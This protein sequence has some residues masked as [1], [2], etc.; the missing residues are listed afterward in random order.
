[1]VK[2]G[3][4]TLTLSGNNSG[5]TGSLVV[6]AGTLEATDAAA[7]PGFG[8]G[9]VSVAVGATLQADLA[10][11]GGDG[12]TSTN[13]ASLLADTSFNIDS[14][15]DPPSLSFL[16]FNFPSGTFTWGSISAAFGLVV[17]G[18]GT[19]VLDGGNSF[20]STDVASGTLDVEGSITGP[21]AAN[22]G[23][24]IG[25]GAPAIPTLSVN[26]S[27]VTAVIGQAALAS[28]QWSDSTT[29]PVTVT[30]P[31]GLLTPNPDG[32]WNWTFTPATPLP[33]PQ[34]ETITA[35]D[36]STNA[37]ATQT[38]TVDWLAP[39]ST[40]VS[41]L[42]GTA[43]TA[44]APVTIQASVS[45]DSGTPA[46][47][48]AFYDGTA[49]LG[50]VPL[51]AAGE[52]NLGGSALAMLKLPTLGP[53]D[54][55]ITAVYE[56]AG[57][58]AASSCEPL[59]VT[60]APAAIAPVFACT[61]SPAPTEGAPCQLDASE[62]GDSNAISSWTVN[63]GDGTSPQVIFTSYDFISVTHAYQSGGV[64]CL[65]HVS[66]TDNQGNTYGAFYQANLSGGLDPQFGV[67]GVVI[68]PLPPGEGQGEGISN[69]AV[70]PDGS[71]LAVQCSTGSPPASSLVRFDASGDPDGTTFDDV[72]S[73]ILAIAAIA[74]QPTVLSAARDADGAILRCV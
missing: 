36:T 47:D 51:D 24:V 74:I 70:Q 33:G 5:F 42:P 56:G 60:V 63:W 58:F 30:A 65:V 9:G 69:L 4:G 35:L 44:A 67:G 38:V 34:T 14:S 53:G 50:T 28:G 8:R 49:L 55:G 40:S 45:A 73:Q 64:T 54:H 20:A 23:Q 41:I 17:Q 3:N 18:D 31:D 52:I 1:M 61:W 37:A 11:D 22:G 25:G 19:L 62:T 6:Q 10:V 71:I 66:E 48:V 16:A 72:S 59:V 13:L 26:N 46:G 57:Y 2:I 39:T 7:L 27:T 43:F 68:S 21:V 12:W 29:D 15:T 32:T